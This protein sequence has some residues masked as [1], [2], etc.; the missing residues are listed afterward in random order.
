MRVFAALLF[1]SAPSCPDLYSLATH[2]FSVPTLESRSAVGT[3]EQHGIRVTIDLAAH[4]PNSIPLSMEGVEYPL[5]V[6]GQPVF[7]GSHD[8]IALAER[9][10]GLL[11]VT[12]V[13]DTSQPVFRE[14]IPGQSANWLL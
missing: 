8:S 12:G 5:S 4:N 2:G 13:I 11:Q 10:D 1:A 9:A 6:Q 7:A 3:P 14:L